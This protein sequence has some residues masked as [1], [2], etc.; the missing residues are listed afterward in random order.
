MFTWSRKSSITLTVFK[1]FEEC[2]KQNILAIWIFTQNKN[3]CLNERIQQ[4]GLAVKKQAEKE[5]G[6]F[7]S[8]SQ[9]EGESRNWKSL[10]HT[11][12][13]W[14]YRLLFKIVWQ[15]D[16]EMQSQMGEVNSSQMSGLRAEQ[17]LAENLG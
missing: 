8:Q 13:I 11:V 6:L 10:L 15:D 1:H 12:H 9:E 14:T 4:C 5:N 16:K 17:H 3:I 7:D 2:C